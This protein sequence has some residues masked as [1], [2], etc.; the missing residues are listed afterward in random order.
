MG[1]M[2]IAACRKAVT[3]AVLALVAVATQWIV[4]GAWDVAE[5]RTIAAGAVTALAVFFIPNDP[6]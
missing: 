1:A 3:P 2:D 4:T 6:A 5:T